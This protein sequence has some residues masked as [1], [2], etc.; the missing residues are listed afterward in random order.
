[1]AASLA[2]RCTVQIAYAIGVAE[3][4]SI[5][6]DTHGTG[7]V[8]DEVIERAVRDTFDLTPGGIIRGLDLRRPIYRS[9]SSLGHFGR[10]RKKTIYLWELTN[11]VKELVVAI[12]SHSEIIDSTEQMTVK[13]IDPDKL[14]ALLAYAQDGGRICPQPLKWKELWEMLPDKKRNGDGWN[15]PLPLILG[16]WWQT[17]G[18][19]KMLRL[20]EHIEYATNHGA[21]DRVNDYLRGLLQDQWH[22]S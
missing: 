8:S 17:T 3:P 4:V 19:E 2:K 22:T 9:T 16:A 5:S 7:V 13:N 6:I 15:P 14:A 10:W 12:N 20:R 11:K 1:M 21:L 18:L